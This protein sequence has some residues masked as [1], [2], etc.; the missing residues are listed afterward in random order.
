LD[1]IE[2]SKA[3]SFK[4]EFIPPPDKSISHRSVIFSSLAKGTSTVRNF[5]RAND[6]LSTVQAFRSLGIDIVDEGPTLTIHGKGL[7]GLREPSD[8]IDCGN[9][10]TTI[11]LLSGV[12]SGNPFFSVLTGDRSLRTRPMGR[13]ITPLSLMGA[14]ISARDNNRYPPLA[15]KGGNL[16]PV[17]Y[18]MPVASAQV[19]SS[20][21]LA[22]LY[23]EG[24]TEIVEPVKSRD[25]SE[26]MLPAYGADLTVGGLS[27]TVRGGRELGALDTQVPGDFSSA[28]FFIVAALLIPGAEITARNVGINPTRTGLIEVLKS[29]GADIAISNIHAV[30]GEPV[31]D[32]YCSRKSPLKA[33]S[34]TGE[35]VPSLIDE[36]PILCVAAALAEGTTTIKGAEEL[37]VKE[38]DRI[39]T[40]A[41]ELKKM[42]VAIEEYPDGLSIQG[43][44]SL[45]GAEVESHGD[46]RIAM[47]MAVAA[48]AAEGKTVINGASAVDISFPGF[49]DIIGRLSS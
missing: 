6:T 2:L 41:S 23:T 28:A 36:F 8:V 22:G 25:H 47:S 43:A 49:F 20:L 27:I 10:G 1:K 7:H 34:I 15:I 33:V 40:I 24:D 46:H 39:K 42:G 44:E 21:I 17:R 29:M 18:V 13:V 38:S 45:R 32:I 11:R 48:L 9:S 26:K 19:K 12:L 14:L 31:A 37:R 3:S 16:I 4:G 35:A 30:S 5:L